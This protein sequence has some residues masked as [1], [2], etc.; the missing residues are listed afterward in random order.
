MGSSGEAAATGF[1]V[2]FLDRRSVTTP[3]IQGDKW[4][5]LPWRMWW[6]SR[7]QNLSIYCLGEI[8]R[9]LATQN[10]HIPDPPTLTSL[11]KSKENPLKKQGSFLSSEHLKS[12][13]KTGQMRHKMHGRSKK[14][15]KKKKAGKSPQ[16]KDLHSSQKRL[17]TEFVLGELVSWKATFQLQENI[18]LKF[19]SPKL[20]YT[21]SFLIQRITWK[22]CFG[23]I[24]SENL[25]SVT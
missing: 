14:Q 5:S 20:H 3:A 9:K 8:E 19:I 25:I 21:Y 12:M 6:S 22:I 24:V 16:K 18:Y 13:E 17:H 23:T 1:R 2:N 10:R 15:K 11:E 7:W 4:L